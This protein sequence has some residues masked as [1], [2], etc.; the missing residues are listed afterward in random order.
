M[1]LK[2]VFLALFTAGG[3]LAAIDPAKDVLLY[4]PF[5]HDPR[6]VQLLREAGVTVVLLPWPGAPSAVSFAQACQAAGIRPVADLSAASSAEEARAFAERARGAGFT[7]VALEGAAFRDEK[8]L[9]AFA[10]GLKG[11]DALVFLKPD[12]L[13]WRVAPALAVLREGQWPG[14]R[15]TRERSRS[16]N[17]MI[18]SASREPWLDANS[19]LVAYLRGLFPERAALVGYR[20]DEAAGV[21]ADRLLPYHSLELALAEAFAAG[22]NVVLHPPDKHHAALLAGRE[23]M[24]AA[25]RALGQTAR[26]LKQR[27][28]WF[29][30]PAA[31]TVVVAAGALEQ[32]GEIL[33]MLH[34][35]N[36]CPAVVSAATIPALERDRWRA[37]VV[38]NVAPPPEAGRKSILNYARAGGLVLT[39]PA[40]EGAPAWWLVKGARKTRTDEDRDWYALGKGTV[41]AY[42]EPVQDP[43]EFAL[44]VIDA[45]GVRVRDLRVWSA[46]TVI[47]LLKRLPGGQLGLALINYGPPIALDF[48]VRVEGRFGTAMM[49]EPAAEASRPLKVAKRSS[50]TEIVVDRLGRLGVVVLQ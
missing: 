13:H 34:R 9:A 6:H 22:G 12:Q 49:Y 10:S 28:E 45:V 3:L 15:R 11:L 2:S 35:R 1:T 42:R 20:P 33:N 19:Y 39:A 36:A 48:P 25:W 27:A 31:S 21:K 40:S 18:S 32:S 24:V 47:G 7:G 4:W 37:V 43:H 41:V 8:A 23:E 38:A 46:G 17:V 30:A 16:E 26:F 14:V 5:G 44:D 29:R 50:G